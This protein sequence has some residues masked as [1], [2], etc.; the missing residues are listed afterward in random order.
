MTDHRQ[1]RRVQFDRE[2]LRDSFDAAVR[3]A[4]ALFQNLDTDPRGIRGPKATIQDPNIHPSRVG[5]VPHKDVN[6]LK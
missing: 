6:D 4:R 3:P 1:R 5:A 2:L